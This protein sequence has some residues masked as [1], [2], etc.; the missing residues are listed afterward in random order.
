M[1]KRLRRAYRALTV[2]DDRVWTTV[3][4][5]LPGQPMFI[6]GAESFL[7]ADVQWVATCI[8]LIALYCSAIELRLVARTSGRGKKLNFPS[9][10]LETNRKEYIAAEY[11][12]WAAGAEDI[13]EIVEHPVL[14]LLEEVNEND[15]QDDLTYRIVK[16][17]LLAGNNF[18]QIE[19]KG[20]LPV[21]LWSSSP[22]RWSIVSDEKKKNRVA[23]YE[24]RDGAATKKYRPEE[25]LHFKIPDVRG[26]LMGKSPLQAAI[27]SV[28]TDYQIRRHEESVFRHA[29]VL[30]GIFKFSD[31]LSATE[32]KVATEKVRQLYGGAT[33][34]GKN[35]TVQGD[36]DFTPIQQGLKDLAHIKGRELTFQEI[37]G[38]YHVPEALCKLNRANLASATTALEMFSRLAI[39]PMLRRIEAV[40]N[41]GLV[42]WYDSTN[43]RLIYDNPVPKDRAQDREDRRIYAEYG[44]RTVNEM[45]IDDGLPPLKDIPDGWAGTVPGLRAASAPPV[46]PNTGDEADEDENDDTEPEKRLKSENDRK[47]VREAHWKAFDKAVTEHE[48]KIEAKARDLLNEMWGEVLANMDSGKTVKVKRDEEQQVQQVA[49]QWLFDDEKWQKRFEKDLYP[50]VEQT[51]VA[52]GESLGRITFDINSSRALN[53]LSMAKNR[54][55]TIPADRWKDILWELIRG[56][57][58]GET[59]TELRDRVRKYQEHDDKYGAGVIARTEAAG[60]Y[61]G[62]LYEAIMQ[63]PDSWGSEWVTTLDGRERESHHEVDG[64]KR[65]KGERFSNGLLHPGEHGAAAKEVIQCRCTILIILVAEISQ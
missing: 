25:V 48:K 45:R 58:R 17:K 4:G 36:V 33:R 47:A 55:K 29:A 39:L 11:K 2:D 51:F 46:N 43:I 49:Q 60:A 61:N 59:I 50:L 57:M 28:N 41:H 10:R 19:S 38:I 52:G 13:V 9:R 64:E 53:V 14:T 21:A 20:G 3:G 31:N 26:G 5:Q 34:A 16:Q 8:D 44:I 65:A 27:D 30:G 22:A 63:D 35:L 37:L 62:G 1:R 42:P 6:P 54:I 12:A 23:R 7:N 56:L 15:N 18:T 32:F 24:Y 40:W